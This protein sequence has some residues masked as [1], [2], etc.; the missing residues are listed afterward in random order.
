MN[1]VRSEV[2]SAGAA[3]STWI[4]EKALPFWSVVGRDQ[5]GLGFIEHLSLSAQPADVPYK[6]VRVQ[7]RQI[8]VFS[9][10]HMLGWPGAI[11]A[12]Q[13]GYDFLIRN[14]WRDD[15]SW[16]RQ[17]E[18]DGRILD[19]RAD[20]YDLAFV[21]FALAWYGRATVSTEPIERALRTLDWI[22][23]TMASPRGGFYNTWP[24]SRELRQQNPHMHLLEA[25]LA[26]FATTGDREC[27]RVA[28]G[29][30]DLFQRHLF[31][32]D[33]GTLGEFFADDWSWAD[34]IKGT[35]VEPGHHYEWVWILSEYERLT[36]H[37]LKSERNA[38]Y[39]FANRFGQ[40][41]G[42]GLVVDAL[43]REGRVR[44][45]SVRIWPQT[46]AIKAH[47]VMAEEQTGSDSGE[48]GETIAARLVTR[49]LEHFFI[50]E[51]AGTWIEHFTPDNEPKGERIPSST[52]YHIFMAF[53][54]L[55]R[56]RRILRAG[57][58][59]DRRRC[60]ESALTKR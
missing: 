46:E 52:L 48:N 15:G 47:M 11:E 37:S 49:L 18:R 53:A 41:P 3:L 6:R 4:F 32:S 44:D 51:P 7:A 13:D 55:S 26:L 57:S 10:A 22:E 28:D 1:A 58:F 33:T 19:P 14:A 34:G 8:Y 56:E 9:Y 16:V 5:S 50:R 30:V 39:F 12:A 27:L 59:A 36:G 60:A 35:L 43:D 21:V 25:V 17:L 38:L 20:L 2:E 29:L 54:E 42:T 45:A 40:R 31:D 24:A 23:S